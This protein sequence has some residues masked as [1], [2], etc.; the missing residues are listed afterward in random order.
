[1]RSRELDL[2]HPPELTPADRRSRD[3]LA[4]VHASADIVRPECAGS[5]MTRRRSIRKSLSALACIDRICA[6]SM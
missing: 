6:I 4:T 5:V 1:M 2:L 3:T